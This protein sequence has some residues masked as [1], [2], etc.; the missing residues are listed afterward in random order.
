MLKII[1]FF[2]QSEFRA[3]FD[4]HGRLTPYLEPIPIYV[5]D[6]AYP[7]LI[8]ARV[9]LGAPYAAVGITASA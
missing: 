4:R 7:A 8:G 6:T 1:E 2:S 9:A 5:I 3:R